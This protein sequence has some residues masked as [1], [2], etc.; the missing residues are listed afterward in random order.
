MGPYAA[1]GWAR[2]GFCAATRFIR[3]DMILL[4]EEQSRYPLYP[5]IFLDSHLKADS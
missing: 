5:E 4:S 3:A 2:A 1:P